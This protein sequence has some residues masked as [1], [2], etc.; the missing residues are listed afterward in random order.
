MIDPFLGNFYDFFRER[1]LFEKFCIYSLECIRCFSIKLNT[2]GNIES[3]V[4]PGYFIE[5]V[6]A[7]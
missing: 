3:S 2:K 7:V 1:C 5:K 6:I 4:Q